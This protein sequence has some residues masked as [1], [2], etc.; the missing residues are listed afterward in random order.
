MTFLHPST[1]TESPPIPAEARAR[2]H[3]LWD[4]LADFGARYVEEALGHA[5]TKLSALLDAQQAFWLGAVRLATESANDPIG[6]WRPST[7]HY[8]HPH[9]S[10]LKHEF[11]EHKRRL[12][13]RDVDPSVVANMRGV[14]RF[15]INI[16]SEIVEPAWW[17]SDFYRTLFAPWEIRDTIS[18]QSY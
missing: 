7:I 16:Q 6:G 13:S 9:E 15:R 5:M 8:L 12:R 10:L 17:R 14:G 1:P 18:T 3:R 4:A 2:I 11:P